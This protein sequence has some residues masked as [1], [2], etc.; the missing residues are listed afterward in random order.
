MRKLAKL[1][2]WPSL[3]IAGVAWLFMLIGGLGCY[4]SPPPTTYKGTAPAFL[5]C[6]V[7]FSIVTAWALV[8]AVILGGIALFWLDTLNRMRIVFFVILM[9]GLLLFRQVF[10]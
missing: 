7:P 9:P 1:L 6:M 3:L 10:W 5:I 4:F 2:F 8:P